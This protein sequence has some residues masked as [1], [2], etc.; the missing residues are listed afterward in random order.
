MAHRVTLRWDGIDRLAVNALS[1]LPVRQVRLSRSEPLQ[2]ALL[3]GATPGV[4]H[5]SRA[6]QT[7]GSCHRVG[8]ATLVAHPCDTG[9]SVQTVDMG[10][11]N[12][13]T[14]CGTNGSTFGNLLRVPSRWGH[15][16]R[17]HPS[18]VTSVWTCR[19]PMVLCFPG[20]LR[21]CFLLLLGWA[22]VGHGCV[23]VRVLFVFRLVTSIKDNLPSILFPC[24]Y[25]CLQLR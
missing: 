15:V 12:C 18:R 1:I 16:F 11:T 9:P 14:A 24:A 3:H 13:G 25:T 22:E 4:A 6:D 19:H 23:V 2:R 20:K 8:R 17:R 5:G 7:G 21:W 10:H